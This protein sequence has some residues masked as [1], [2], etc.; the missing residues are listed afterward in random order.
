MS[1]LTCATVDLAPFFIDEGVVIGE[2]ATPAQLEAAAVIDRGCREHGFMHVVNFGLSA[3]LEK[4]A[5]AASRELFSLPESVKRSSLSR[6]SL[7]N[8][9]Y[10]PFAFEHLNRARPADLKEAFNVREPRVHDNDF[11]GT[12]AGFEPVAQ[13][14]WS[15][16][17]TAARR[18]ALA[19]AL[20]LGLETNYFTRTLERLDLCTCRFLHYPPCDAPTSSPDGQ[21][22]AI[23]VGEH[24]D[25]GAYTFL[26]LG[27]GARGLQVKPVRGGESGGA[28]G[29][30]NDSDWVDVEA[31]ATPDGTVG[32]IV[33]TGALLARWTNDVWRA[34][35]HRVIVPDAEV[36]ANDRYS[37]AIFIDPDAE[38]PVA[39]DPRFVPPGEVARYEPTTGLEYLMMKLKEAQ[40]V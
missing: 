34:T 22:A 30:E 4:K 36:A 6:I 20:A 25:F 21:L 35:A 31:P 2:A 8:T 12:P 14:L 38:A 17:E 1:P 18:Y 37:I 40:G 9:G 28:H 29:G 10:A 5:F 32:A 26:L 24:T 27:E 11:S 13:E 33:N 15:V 19:L 39:V 7:K 23:R 3:V 16:I